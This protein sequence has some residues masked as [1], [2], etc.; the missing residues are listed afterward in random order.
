MKRQK[1][2]DGSAV[3]VGMPAIDINYRLGV[4]HKKISEVERNYRPYCIITDDDVGQPGN[5]PAEVV[6]ILDEIFA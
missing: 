1:I 5:D 6:N 3:P 4:T 2:N